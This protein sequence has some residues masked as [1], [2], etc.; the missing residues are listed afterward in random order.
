MSKDKK[1]EALGMNFTTAHYRLTRDLLFN[2]VKDEPCFRCGGKLERENFSIDHKESWLSSSN[3]KDMFFSLDNISYSHH[4]CNS[5]ETS[6]RKYFTD[7]DRKEGK[8]VS[9]RKWDAKYKPRRQERRNK[10][11]I[12]QVGGASGS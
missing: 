7:E 3:P 4:A 10:R 9:N 6:Q 1:S 2:L 12:A 5:A 8:R 11:F